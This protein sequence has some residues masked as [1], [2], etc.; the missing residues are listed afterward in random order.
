MSRRTGRTRSLNLLGAILAASFL[1][2]CQTG[3]RA[4]SGGGVDRAVS[5]TQAGVGEAALTPLTD[6]NLRREPIPPR[7]KAIRSPYE[8]IKHR[9][10]AG[11]S[12]E[13]TELTAILGPDVDVAAGPGETLEQKAGDGAADLALR[14]V[15]D[16][17]T[18]FIPYRSLVRMATGA[19]EHERELR[20]AYDRG[21][22]RRSYLKGVGLALGCAP[23][24]APDPRYA[25]ERTRPDIE[26][27][28]P[29]G[30][31]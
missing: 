8:A 21:I 10:C 31:R 9:N 24:A 30:T 23:P 5:R 1:T 28:D 15:R 17:V 20:A 25:D 3:P 12:A 13:V 16:A 7:L 19:S 27:R 11:L 22:Q 14:G 4:G 26:Y 29:D 18:G 2:G 6:L